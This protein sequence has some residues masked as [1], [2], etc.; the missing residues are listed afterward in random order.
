[1]TLRL[2]ARDERY[3]KPVAPRLHPGTQEVAAN[4][5]QRDPKSLRR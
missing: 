1:M 4:E 2:T 5:S 3:T